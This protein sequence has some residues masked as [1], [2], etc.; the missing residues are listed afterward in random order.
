[1]VH[2]ER[3]DEDENSSNAQ[4]ES[5]LGE[6]DSFDDALTGD[7]TVEE[8]TEGAEEDSTNSTSDARPEPDEN[9][10]ET[11]RDRRTDE[12]VIDESTTPGEDQHE[13]DRDDPSETADSTNAGTDVEIEAK[14]SSLRETLEESRQRVDELENRLDDY[15][16]RNDREHEELRK[17]AV[18]DFAREMLQVKDMLD[19]AI[20]LEDFEPDTERRLE[21]IEQQFENVLT[22][23]RIELIE[24]D[25]RDPYDNRYHRMEEKVQAEGYEPNQVVH[26]LDVG[27]RASDRVIRPARVKVAASQDD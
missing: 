5:V 3:D 19:D 25:E 22:S 6:T 23:G 14:L 12:P 26:V 11:E 16:R 21:M 13:S 1:M 4:P 7:G 10:G 15:E 20:R 2:D 8:P 27:Y 17:Y 18:E 24:P 9:E